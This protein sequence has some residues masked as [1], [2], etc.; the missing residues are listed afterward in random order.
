MPELPEVEIIKQSL[1]KTVKFDKILKVK[2]HNKNLRFKLSKNFENTLKNK[3]ITNISRYAK[4]LIIELNNLEY[5]IF[6]FGMSGTLHLKKNSNIKSTNLSFY[7]SQNL[8]NKH[9]HVELIFKNFKIIYND[10]RRFGYI[11]LIKSKL[12][13]GSFISKIG[14]EPLDSKFNIL[15]LK[16]K[17]FNRNKNIKNILLDQKIISGIGNIYASEILFHSRLNPLKKGKKIKI[18]ELKLLVK[19]SKRVLHNAI[20]KGGSSIRDFKNTDGSSGLFQNEFKV[21]NKENFICPNYKCK[22]KIIKINISNRSSFYCL[23]CQKK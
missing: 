14:L 13:L 7:S 21:Y 9:N 15:Y 1:K 17:L 5:L 8:P 6:H 23:N 20:S 18:N 22:F 12:E 2:V 3:K 4:Y 16:K 11:K 10:P 19:F